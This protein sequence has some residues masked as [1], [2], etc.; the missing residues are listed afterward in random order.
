MKAT[1]LV[2]LVACGGG[3]AAGDDD[4]VQPDAP[5]PG[6]FGFASIQSFD[7][8]NVP[9]QPLRGGSASAGFFSNGRICTTQETIGPCI[10]QQCDFNATPPAISAGAITLTGGTRPIT[11]APAADQT[12]PTLNV[13]T[14]LLFDPGATITFSAAGAEVPA[15]EK[16]LAMPAKATITSPAEPP[17]GSP[18]LTFDRGQDFTV[19]WS[20]GGEGLMQIALFG[21]DSSQLISCRFEASAGSGTLPASALGRLDA[22]QGGFSMA[23]FTTTEEFA[24]DWAVELSGIF[25]AVWPDNS[26]VSGPTMAR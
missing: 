11:L 10:V 12:Y 13:Q 9:N 24:G 7:A 16:S 4:D 22:G 20:G 21:P 25:N 15:F 23:V 26:I 1:L 5:R 18:F 14:G 6:Q 17:S 3:G 2:L 19:T 8:M